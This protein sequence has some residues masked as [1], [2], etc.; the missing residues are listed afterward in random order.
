L[1]SIPENYDF[2]PIDPI[3][4]EL[5]E[6]VKA[7]KVDLSKDLPPPPV[8][9][10][11]NGMIFGTIGNF[12]LL[13]G[14]AKSKKTFLTTLGMAGALGS[15]GIFEG[16]LP[17]GKDRVIFVDTEQG[18]YHVLRVGKRVLR[19]LGSNSIP[20]NFDVYCFRTLLY[21]ERHEAIEH[22]IQST[23]DLGL[24]VIDGIK[25]LIKSINDEGEAT[26]IADDL[27][28]WTEEYQIHI[29][30]VLHQNKGDKNARGH[31]GTE[32]INKAETTVS[33]EREPKTDVSKVE[34]E[35][36][37][38]KEFQPFGFLVNAEGLPEVVEGW[39]Q[40]EE[41]RAKGIRVTPEDLDPYKHKQIIQEIAGKGERFTNSEL[42]EQIVLAVGKH[43]DTIGQSKAKTFKT[44][45]ANEG[46]LIHHGKERSPN[47]FYTL[48]IEGGN[49][50]E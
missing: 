38:D 34:V 11:V 6:K 45:Y 22:L 20:D 10:K 17:P 25:D 47:A 19:L 23:P 27:L 18:E 41:D 50:A 26:L 33:V 29:I 1:K 15:N 28:R 44:Y 24:L 9:L 7:R 14:K 16:C 36:S 43:Y 31:V 8:A 12:S 4:P 30:T 42:I 5:S 48:K 32:L 21:H 3:E 40:K 49:D 46:Y 35:Y 39:K 2:D 13:T 37:R